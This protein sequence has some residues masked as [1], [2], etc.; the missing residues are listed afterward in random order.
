MAPIHAA[1][2]RADVAYFRRLLAAGVYP[3]ALDALDGG[4]HG[5]TP[6]MNLCE[7]TD[8]ESDRVA[9]FKLLREA[10]ANLEALSS[11]TAN[12]VLHYAA[13]SGCVGI[14][15]LVIE[16][17]VNVNVV[18]ND[19]L[20]PLAMAFSRRHRRMWPLLLR[21]GAEIPGYYIWNSSPDPY[22]IRVHRA[23]GFKKYAQ[24]H[25]AAMTK[26]FAANGRR[27]PPEVVRQ[28]MKFWLHLGCY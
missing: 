19:G 10:G 13:I 26:L 15:S 23:G 8:R 4:Q 21:A 28:I 17:G 6:L 24:Q 27:L 25:L 11:P 3:D 1:A 14:M 9:C 20:T 22:F 2:R 18:N 16:A 7:W 5:L 12:T